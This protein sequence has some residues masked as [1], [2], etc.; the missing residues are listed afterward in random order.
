MT[1]PA[2]DELVET[3][4]KLLSGDLPG[5]VL[6]P[7]DDA[8][9]VDMGDRLGVLTTDMLVEGVDFEPGLIS[10]HDLGYK[11][12]S[13]NVSDVAAMGGSPRFALVSLGLPPDVEA[14]WVVE[15]YGGLREAADEYALALVGGDVSMAGE[16]VVSVAVSGEVSRSGAVTRSGAT[17]GE[18]IV[19]TGSLGGAAG[20]LLL[21][22]QRP[23]DAGT[24]WG[25]ELLAAFCR[26]VARV[27]EGQTLAQFGATAMIDVSDGLLLDL[28]RLCRSSGCGAMVDSRSVPVNPAVD[29]LAEVLSGLGPLRLAL[30]GGEDFELVATLPQEVVDAATATLKE[31]FGT[32]LTEIGEVTEEPTLLLRDVNGNLRAMEPKGWDHFAR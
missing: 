13:V 8:A 20:G 23:R 25:R 4:R 2:E 10:A 14:S 31:R 3:I 32:P 27:G 30:E 15:L 26:P 29:E 11:A 18:R 16:I 28:S 17:G 12:V 19:V 6:G 5:V 22:R 7:G 1:L 21:A 9:L 24:P